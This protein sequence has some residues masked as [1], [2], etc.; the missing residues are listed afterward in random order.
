MAF[1]NL[2][3]LKRPVDEMNAV[4]VPW[5]VTLDARRNNCDV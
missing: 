1:I 4:N 2:Q 3:K 5:R